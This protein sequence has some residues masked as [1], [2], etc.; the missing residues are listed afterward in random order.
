MIITNMAKHFCLINRHRWEVFKLS[1][2]L[3]IPIRGFLHDLSK[4]S[5]TEFVESAKYYDGGRSPITLCKKEKGY[6]EAWLHHKGRNK[7]H[8][9]YWVDEKAPNP[10]PMIPYKYLREMVCDQVAAGMVY[11]GKKWVKEYQLSYWNKNK[12]KFRANE[13]IKTFL[14]EVYEQL[15]KEG[16]DKTITKK[17]I[18]EIYEKTCM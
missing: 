18:R 14:T 13:K 15:A 7:H 2:R 4:F 12:D 1:I 9:E 3:G 6:S 10:T 17:N 5:W 16:L 11:Q 8:V